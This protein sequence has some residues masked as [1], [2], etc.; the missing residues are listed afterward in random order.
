MAEPFTRTG[1]AVLLPP[2]SELTA[3]VDAWLAEQI[4]SGRLGERMARAL[5]VA[6][7][8]RAAAPVAR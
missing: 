6:A 3:R 1:K 5:D 8:Q 4:E 7:G 2:R